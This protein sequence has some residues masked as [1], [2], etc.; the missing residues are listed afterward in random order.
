M[1]K[2]IYIICYW[3]FTFLFPTFEIIERIDWNDLHANK[4]SIVLLMKKKESNGD[5]SFG[6]SPFEWIKRN[7]SVATR[8]SEE[9]WE[10]ESESN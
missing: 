9:N 1:F 10:R 8:N 6:I 4:V 2:S 7:I 5:S 3:L